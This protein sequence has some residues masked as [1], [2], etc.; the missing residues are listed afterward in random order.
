MKI[1]CLLLGSGGFIGSNL[2]RS[3]SRVADITL[4]CPRSWELDLTDRS[5]VKAYF[6][7]FKPDVLINA[8]IKVDTIGENIQSVTNLLAALTPDTH[9]IQI[10]SGAEYDRFNCPKNVS[11]AYWGKHVPGDVYGISKYVST[12]LL[13]RHLGSGYLN[14]RV[15][16]IFGSGEESRRLIPSLTNQAVREKTAQIKQDG[17]FSYV[18]VNDLAKF[19]VFWINSNVKVHGTFNFTQERP[20][21]LSEPLEILEKKIPNLR[22]EILDTTATNNF[23]Y[24]NSDLLLKTFKWFT[25]SDLSNGVSQYIDSLIKSISPHD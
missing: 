2:K 1:N 23:Y 25:F 16:G 4:R 12:L 5:A 3:I 19:I 6:Q 15:F 21:R 11:E 8:A 24:G 9:F 18:S 17:L 10:G 22:T 20:L 7:E 13:D 14:L